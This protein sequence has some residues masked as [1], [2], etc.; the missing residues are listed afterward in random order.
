MFSM[1]SL[2]WD[3]TLKGQIKVRWILNEPDEPCSF[4][5]FEKYEIQDSQFP[6]YLPSS[7]FTSSTQ[8]N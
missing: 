8:V 6:K 5:I 2:S 7:T 3:A 1:E 4:R